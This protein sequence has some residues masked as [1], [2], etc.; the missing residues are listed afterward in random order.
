[1]AA[2]I[3]IM[4]PA[5]T[6]FYLVY[7]IG[8]WALVTGVLQIATAIQLRRYITGEWMLILAG[9]ASVVFGILVV[10]APVAGALAIALW[11][12]V[13]LVFFGV[14]MVGLGIRLRGRTRPIHMRSPISLPSR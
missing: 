5:I 8:A 6:A 11:A 13:Y 12:G 3:T 9:L 10:A 1:M 7:L 14:L 2:A 4:W